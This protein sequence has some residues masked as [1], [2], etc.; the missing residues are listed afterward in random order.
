MCLSTYLKQ[1]YAHYEETRIYWVQFKGY[2]SHVPSLK[3]KKELKHL[4]TE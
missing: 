4:L 2:N 3:E 1:G